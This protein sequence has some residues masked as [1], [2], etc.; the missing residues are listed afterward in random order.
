M[1]PDM[2]LPHKHYP[3]ETVSGVLDGVIGP[4]DADS[5]NCPSEKT[6]FRWKH[7]LMF[8]HLNIDGQMKSIGCRVLGFKEELLTSSVSLLQY[9]RS[10]LPDAWLKTIIRYIY[11][12]GSGLQ[13]FY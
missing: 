13:A 2:L 11:N 10:S 5:E 1:L 8:N 3:E 7:W 12:S 6:M 9:M 4:D